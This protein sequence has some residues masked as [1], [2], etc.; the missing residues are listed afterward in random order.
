MTAVVA[1]RSL[2]DLCVH[3][4]ERLKHK[5][6]IHIDMH[7]HIPLALLMTTKQNLNRVFQRDIYVG[8]YKD[9]VGMIKRIKEA[10]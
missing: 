7:V 6:R 8:V 4:K 5:S 2:L 1:Y 9:V 10:T 3:V